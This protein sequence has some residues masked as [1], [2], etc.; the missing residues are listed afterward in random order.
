MIFLEF[1]FNFVG[2]SPSFF[3]LLELIFADQ[4]PSVKSAKIKH[5]I[6]KVLHGNKLSKQSADSLGYY[7]TIKNSTVKLSA[8]ARWRMV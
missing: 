2:V 5:R 3:F 6:T 1:K 7:F 4:V 8:L